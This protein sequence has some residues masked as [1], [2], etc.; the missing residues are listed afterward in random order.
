[1][2]NRFY[3]NLELLTNSSS[4]VSNYC[5]KLKLW[6]LLQKHYRVWVCCVWYIIQQK[7]HH[8]CFFIETCIDNPV[9]VFSWYFPGAGPWRWLWSGVW[10]SRA[11]LALPPPH[12]LHSFAGHTPPTLHHP[13]W[14]PIL[15]KSPVS[16]YHTSIVGCQVWLC[17]QIWHTKKIV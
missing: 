11:P 7:S 13:Q 16:K 10:Y 3:K 14:S 12:T 4:L 15:G 2:Q 17:Y 5:V 6:N 1:M 8:V 9:L